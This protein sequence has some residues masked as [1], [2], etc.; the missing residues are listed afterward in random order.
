MALC[1]DASRLRTGALPRVWAAFAEVAISIL[2]L[3]LTPGIKRL[4]SQLR[5]RPNSAGELL[6]C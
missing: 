6:L 4:M 1:A 2:R 5:L 3:L